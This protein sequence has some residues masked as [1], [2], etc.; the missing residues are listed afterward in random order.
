R[1]ETASQKLFQRALKS[2][3]EWF[4]PK[5]EKPKPA[6]VLERLTKSPHVIKRIVVIG[7]HGW[8][9]NRVLQRV[10][11]EPTGTSPRF[12]EKMDQAVRQFFSERYNITLPPDAIELMPLEG[13]GKIE[14]RVEI[15]YKAL[16]ESELG[17][18]RKLGEADLVFV[19]A[20]SQG[21]PVSILLL[22]RLIKEGLVDVTRQKVSVLAM[23]GISHGPF[24]ALKSSLILKYF[25]ADH[26]RELF[27]FN[28]P[29]SEISR[30]YQDA[31]RQILGSG[32]RVIA[33]GS[34]Y[35][36]VV[37]LYSAVMHGYNHPNIYRGL[38]IDG[39]DYTP[40]F[41]SH[42]VVYAL[43]LR[44]AGLSDHDL[45]IHLSEP[46][47]GNVYGFGTQGHSVIYE[48]LNV[49]T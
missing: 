10:V 13:E 27:E 1:K 33:V 35:D 38:Y 34:W 18:K 3:N 43:K 46:L 41:L 15:L 36:Q 16:V 29:D 20:H 7:V 9:P 23:A 19:A 49:Y 12:V 8:F 2:V 24:P 48:E 26:A 21:T 4:Y 44:N 11:G 5:R 32:V 45:A 25:E 40:D 28:N 17:W 47:A 22:A 39:A 37:P 42:L 6:G 31:M 30:K 14:R